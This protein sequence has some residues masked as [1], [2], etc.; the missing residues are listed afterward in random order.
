MWHIGNAGNC[1]YIP[2]ELFVC[3]PMWWLYTNIL[4]MHTEVPASAP[5]CIPIYYAYYVYLPIPRWQVE[6][7]YPG[8]AWVAELPCQPFTKFQILTNADTEIKNNRYNVIPKNIYK[9]TVNQTHRKT[10]TGKDRDALSSM[11]NFWQITPRLK[12]G[13][14]LRHIDT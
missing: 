5:L 13:S 6:C 8:L 4:C 10:D 9:Y 7:T 1:W 2:L 14:K 3:L 11:I 12:N